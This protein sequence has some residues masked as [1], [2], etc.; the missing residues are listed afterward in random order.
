[1]IASP[2]GDLMER[3]MS[4]WGL[5][6]LHVQQSSFF[7]PASYLPWA[8]LTRWNQTGLWTT[9]ALVRG[10][11][12]D[13]SSAAL[14][15]PSANSHVIVID[16]GP[17]CSS[18]IANTH[19]ADTHSE[20][21]HTCKVLHPTKCT[22]THTHTEIFRRPRNQG[23]ELSQQYGRLHRGVLL[24][25]ISLLPQTSVA[26]FTTEHSVP[27]LSLCIYYILPGCN[28]CTIFMP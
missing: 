4:R 8:R 21:T 2:Q 16:P 9:R 19:I 3:K 15:E 11:L 27:R 23:R 13:S 17:L 14:T 20:H 24:F 18:V 28:Y 22:H 6:G 25:P 12:F 5:G 1:M 7:S 26:A 10:L